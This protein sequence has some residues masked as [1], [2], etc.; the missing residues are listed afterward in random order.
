VDIARFNPSQ[1]GSFGI[2]RLESRFVEEFAL[3][4]FAGLPAERLASA[5]LVLSVRAVRTGTAGGA[6][7]DAVIELHG[8][9]G[10]GVVS[11]ADAEVTNQLA[12]SARIAAPGEVRFDV[13]AFVRNLI[14]TG[15]GHAGFQFRN[16][17]DRA[18]VVGTNALTS[19]QQRLEVTLV[20]IP[21]PASGIALAAG[22]ACVAAMVG[23][24]RHWLR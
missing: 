10:N 2:G 7:P 15:A 12:T 11:V 17:V 16:V 24:R 23:R 13:T 6:V 21:E 9:R 14:G 1:F 4:D 3:A 8:Y 5:R 19:G 22:L 20:P 18:F